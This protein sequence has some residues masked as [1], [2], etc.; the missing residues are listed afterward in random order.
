MYK[1]LTAEK[2]FAEIGRLEEA[3]ESGVVVNI[4]ERLWAGCAPDDAF[5][6]DVRAALEA[7]VFHSGYRP[8][9]VDVVFPGD[10]CI[11]AVESQN[12]GIGGKIFA[13][14]QSYLNERGIKA[15]ATGSDFLLADMDERKVY[16]IG[17]YGIVP[18]DGMWE[19]TV[20]IYMQADMGIIEAFRREPPEMVRRGLGD[21]GVTAEELLEAISAVANL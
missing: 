1:R 4:A 16:K 17:S 8:G 13:A 6:E 10:L 20:H 2:A 15:Q 19:T 21:F 18:V 3:R 14:A 5:R 11:C 12:S 7:P 9:M